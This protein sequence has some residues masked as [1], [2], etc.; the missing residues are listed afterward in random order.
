MEN[1]SKK[2]L[3]IVLDEQK[4]QGIDTRE[5][6]QKMDCSYRAIVY[7]KKGERNISLQ[8]AEKVLDALGYEIKIYKKG[9]NNDQNGIS[10]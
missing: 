10:K 4:R 2:I 5:L 8:M 9:E 6:A 1:L 7:W 3:Y